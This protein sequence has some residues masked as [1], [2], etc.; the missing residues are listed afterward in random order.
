MFLVYCLLIYI[1]PIII[2]LMLMYLDMDKG[3]SVRDYLNSY[4][5]DILGPIFIPVLNAGLVV[6][7]IIIHIIDWVK[8]K[9]LNFKK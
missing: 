9:F 4:E 5:S 1:V 3:E 6:F 7:F 8:P 2:F